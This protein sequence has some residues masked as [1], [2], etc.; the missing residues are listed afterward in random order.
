[1]TKENWK[2]IKNFKKSEK[3]VF[4]KPAFDNSSKLEF[5]VLKLL[6][7]QTTFA[8]KLYPNRKVSCIIHTIVNGTHSENSQHYLGLAVDIHYR[9]LTLIEQIMLS[10]M[11]GW[12]AIGFYPTWQNR[13][14]HLDL[15]ERKEYESLLM[16]Y[17]KSVRDDKGKSQINYIYEKKIVLKKI[18]SL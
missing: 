10:L 5:R 2:E 4:D 8:K 12:S 15:R 14:L 1:M 3:N 17:T 13:G 9:S 11:F 16:W 7:V 6:D 18:M